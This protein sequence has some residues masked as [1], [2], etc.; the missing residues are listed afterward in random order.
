MRFTSLRTRI[1]VLIT[2]AAL[3]AA[4]ATALVVYVGGRNAIEAE[5]FATLTAVR[6]NKADQV[7]EFFRQTCDQ[8]VTFSSITGDTDKYIAIDAG[9][10]PFLETAFGQ[11]T[12]DIAKITMTGGVL[13]ASHMSAQD[14]E[15]PAEDSGVN[16][17]F[18]RLELRLANECFARIA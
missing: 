10:I 17:F 18:A 13:D 1:L 5:A 3:I 16:V 15:V 7:E 14:L 12:M 2:V 6:E 8:V 4:G 11:R 9:G